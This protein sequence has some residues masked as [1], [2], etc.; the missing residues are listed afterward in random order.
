MRLTTRVHRGAAVLALVGLLS[1]CVASPSGAT[2]PDST[3]S[4]DSPDPSVVQDASPEVVTVGNPEDEANRRLEELPG[5]TCQAW[6]DAFPPPLPADVDQRIA[7]AGGAGH[8]L[9]EGDT[10]VGDA[11]SAVDAFGAT[12]A[13]QPPDGQG[14]MWIELVIEGKVT[15]LKLLPQTTKGGNQ[16]WRPVGSARVAPCSP[17]GE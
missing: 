2:G 13:A 7:R 9:K 15:E 1:G 17:D 11:A 12:W 8:W 6:L 4:S 16:V 3:P 5:G 14:P 10:W